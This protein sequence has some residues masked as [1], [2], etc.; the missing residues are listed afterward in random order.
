MDAS[1]L[2]INKEYRVFCQAE[3]TANNSYGHIAK[4]FNTHEFPDKIGIRV[5]PG[6]GAPHNT[7]FEFVM[8]KPLSEALKCVFGYKNTAGEVLIEDLSWAG[9]HFSSQQ[10]HIKT[11]LPSN[12]SGSNALQVFGRCSDILGRTKEADA[13]ITIEGGDTVKFDEDTA[14]RYIEVLN[15]NSEMGAKTRVSDIVALSETTVRSADSKNINH[16]KLKESISL[17]NKVIGT[18]K[19]IKGSDFRQLSM[20]LKN[21]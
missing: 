13:I 8:I 17:L 16:G 19:D 21:I 12:D 2:G 10:Q 18:Q 9:Q 7:I 5:S 6:R 20:V 3:N 4:R 15:K 1:F 11:T 14:D